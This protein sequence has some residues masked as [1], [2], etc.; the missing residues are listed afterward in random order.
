MIFNKWFPLDNEWLILSIIFTSIIFLIIASYYL[1]DKGLIT[2]ESNRRLIH[3][4]IGLMISMSPY[5]FTYKTYPLLLAFFFIVLN[6]L[7]FKTK[8]FSG[9]HSQN[10]KSY[11]TIYFP[12]SYLIIIFFFWEQSH[13]VALSLLILALSDPIAAQIGSYRNSVWKYKVWKDS[14][15][16]EGTIAF[17]ASTVIILLIGTYFFMDYHF[18]FIIGFILITS[19]FT[20]I[21]EITSKMGT[22]NLSIPIVS[23]LIMIGLN[24]EFLGQPN[25]TN[26]ITTIFYIIIMSIILFFPYQIKSL[27]L[28]GY[29]GSIT[30]GTLIILYGK[31]YHFGLLALFFILSSL[32]NII[33]KEYSFN[34]PKNSKREVVQV[35]CNGGVALVICIY[36]YFNPNPISKYLFAASIAAAMADTWGTEFGKLSK[37][38]PI[39]ILSFKT[40]DHGLSGG[41]TRTGTIGSLLGSSIIGLI[42]WLFISSEEPLIFGVIIIGFLSAVLDSIIGDKFQ[43]KYQT[44]EGNIV[45]EPKVDTNIISGYD[46]INNNTVNFIA[47]LTAPILMYF[48]IIF[49]N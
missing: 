33:L 31:L 43:G 49:L 38:K 30:M 13:F 34:K 21:S 14:K 44:R 4:A 25:N 39:S 32:L 47:T 24:N 36:E 45:E 22:D 29:F 17:F 42:T 41:I 27:S 37:K 1:L 46:L 20:T 9:I 6:T 12:L 3:I 40:I 48:F 26:L 5:I 7:A 23:I 35:F 28:S 8:I 11:G 2:P 10:R 18:L 15:T 19:V 16:I